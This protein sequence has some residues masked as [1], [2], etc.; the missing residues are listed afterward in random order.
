MEEAA[1][2]LLRE[3]ECHVSPRATAGSLRVGDQQLIEIAKALS[4]QSDILIMD[5]PTS[6]LTE[7]EVGR[8]YRVIERLRKRGVTILYISHKMEEVFHLADRITILREGRLVKTLNRKETTPRDV[9]NVM[10]GG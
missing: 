1:G 6:A 7:A 5:E 8:L 9:T 10:V 2:R 3:L 4:L